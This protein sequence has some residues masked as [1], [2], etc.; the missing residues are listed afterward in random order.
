MLIKTSDPNSI[1]PI[2]KKLN[3][4][5]AN[6]H[7]GQNGRVLIIG[8]SS[9]FHSASIWAAEIVSH[10]VDMVH[11]SST[12][13]NNEIFLSL[14]KKFHNGI[15]V[16]QSNLL[17]YVE[18]DDAVLIGPGMVRG[19]KNSEFR[20]QNS[21]I[22]EIIKIRDEAEY[23]QQLTKYLIENY[24]EKRFVFDAGALQMMDK[25]WL[26]ELKVPA[27]ITPHQKEFESL[28]DLSIADES[29]EDKAQIVKK[30]AKDYNCVILLKAINDIVS[31]GE[32]L[33]IIQGGNQGLTK[34]G[35][36]DILAGL[37][38]SWRAKNEPVVSAAVAS[39]ILKKI[40]DELFLSH[41]Y[42]YNVADILAKI[43]GL[44][45]KL[46]FTKI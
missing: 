6:S 12:Q 15:V 9:L 14:K 20:I 1:K 42:W 41:G 11:Y 16:P 8:G 24:P 4:P 46:F 13:E 39:L 32:E 45:R 40:S 26:K 5:K 7:K 23:T 22:S 29:Q 25:E 19:K 37:T 38:V 44:L 2:F 17:H 18:E 21:K 3:L 36:G 43:P 33:Y 35:T 34:G 28:F 10:I 27:I 30:I 31:D